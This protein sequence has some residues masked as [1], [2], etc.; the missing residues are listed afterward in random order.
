M[1]APTHADEASEGK[2]RAIANGLGKRQIIREPTS[3]FADNRSQAITQRKLQEFAD[4][5]P[6]VHPLKVHQ[7]TANISPHIKAL[8]SVPWNAVQQKQGSTKPTMQMK[9]DV[10]V[11]DDEGLK[12]EA[13]VLGNRA[14][15]VG[16]KFLQ[17]KKAESEMQ[18]SSVIQRVVYPNMAAMWAAVHPGYA[19]ANIAQD[20]VLSSLYNDA[21]AQLPNVDFNPV[22]GQ[23]PQITS[24]PMAPQAFRLDYD[25]NANLALDDDYYAGA[26]IH[27]L[28]HAAS[29]QQ[30]RRQGVNQNM[31]VFANLNLPAPVGAVDP[32]TGM[33]PN[34][35][36]SYQNQMRTIDDNW[37]DLS[38]I[39]QMD[40]NSGA[41]GL[42]DYNHIDARIQYAQAT[43][44]VHNETVLGDM[45]YYLKAKNLE[46]SQ[47]YK[48]ARRMLKEANDR[49]QN[50]F[51]S[52]ADTEIRRV[53][54]RAWW[55][56]FWK[57]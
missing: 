52:N 39:A 51:W 1:N 32:G 55:F 15:K 26:I 35:L 3:Q 23:A 28:V 12:K 40:N 4:G 17:L 29:S 45:M 7:R 34:Q 2:S 24:T 11:K 10:N 42:V 57:W 38:A 41:L 21:A 30:Y 36:L 43:S 13:D 14:L 50:G 47:T 20:S 49:R 46:G 18:N 16:Q 25:L 27:E 5:I 19:L 48:F 37:Q 44:F 6:S 53:D 54:S 31:M 22:G 56:Q 33:A 8:P 9:R